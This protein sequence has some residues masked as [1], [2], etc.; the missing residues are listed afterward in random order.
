MNQTFLFRSKFS[1]F[2]KLL[3]HIQFIFNIK[4]YIIIINTEM[5]LILAIN[6]N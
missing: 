2:L 1:S 3:L 5:I 4:C 6:I